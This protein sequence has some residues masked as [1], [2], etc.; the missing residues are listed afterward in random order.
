VHDGSIVSE[1]EVIFKIYIDI[2]RGEAPDERQFAGSIRKQPVRKEPGV[3]SF[4]SFDLSDGIRKLLVPGRPPRISIFL[5]SEGEVS[6]SGGTLMVF[7]D[8]R[9]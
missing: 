3:S 8:E 5:E 4:V 6:F 9:N 1:S 2:R 7:I